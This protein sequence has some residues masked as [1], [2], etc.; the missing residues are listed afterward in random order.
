[1]AAV[2]LHQCLPFAQADIRSGSKTEVELAN[3]DFRFTPQSRQLNPPSNA[4]FQLSASHFRS[5]P[6]NGHHQTGAVGPV[7]AGS[8]RSRELQMQHSQA[9][10]Q[11]PF[12]TNGD[13]KQPAGQ[14]SKDLSS[15][16]G[17]NIPLNTSGKS[18][19]QAR[20][21]PPG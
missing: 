13:G 17:E 5:T 3:A 16:V 1:V 21:V 6:I 12:L 19:L 8:V 14:I 10:K 11:L 7:G 9:A 4:P 15:P 20:P 18:P 2:D